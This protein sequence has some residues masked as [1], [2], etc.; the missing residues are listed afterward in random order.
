VVSITKG[1]DKNEI[2]ADIKCMPHN[3][4]YSHASNYMKMLKL[5]GVHMIVANTWY[6]LILNMKTLISFAY[7]W[8]D[9]I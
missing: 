2:Y 7:R 6:K 9:G 4:L 8:V 3:C 5:L 1:C